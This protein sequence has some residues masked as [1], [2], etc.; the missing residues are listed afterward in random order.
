MVLGRLLSFSIDS[1]KKTSTAL[2]LDRTEL[3]NDKVRASASRCRWS[4][5]D[6]LNGNKLTV[7]QSTFVAIENAQAEANR[8]RRGK[9]SSP[10]RIARIS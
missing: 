7:T 8:N 1:P 3:L 10:S 6:V 5:T 2:K 4:S 9:E